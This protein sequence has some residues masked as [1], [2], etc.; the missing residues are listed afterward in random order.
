MIAF[1]LQPI[2]IFLMAILQIT[3][4]DFFSVG[5]LSIDLAFVFVIYAGLR[6]NA[7]RGALLSFLLGFFLDC[8]VSPIWGLHMFLY[9]LFFYISMIAGTK[10]DRKNHLP[11]AV[12]T[13]ICLL[14]QGALKIL[15]Y[16]LILDVDILYTVPKMFIPQAIATGIFSPFLYNI[17]NYFEDF[18]NAEV[19]QP[20][21]RL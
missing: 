6:F 9:V 17:F 16:W 1:L 11:V 18:F 3:F 12:F 19:R 2:F 8:I 4:M 5:P 20:A 21:R 14:L 7:M 10:I 15:F 13:G